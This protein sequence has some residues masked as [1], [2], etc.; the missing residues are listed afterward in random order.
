MEIKIDYY[1]NTYFHLHIKL[2]CIPFTLQVEHGIRINCLDAPG[3]N[4]SSEATLIALEISLKLLYPVL[5]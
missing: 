5:K 1:Y 4:T 2:T 3:L